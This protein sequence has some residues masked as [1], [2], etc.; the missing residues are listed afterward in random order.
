LEERQNKSSKSADE[1]DEKL[2]G[3]KKILDQLK[4]GTAQSEHYYQRR[5]L[6]FI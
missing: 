4:A 1:A 3:V 5:I 6:H 2:T